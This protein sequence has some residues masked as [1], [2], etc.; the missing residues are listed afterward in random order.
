[1]VN[2]N[3][4][5]DLDSFIEPKKEPSITKKCCGN[6]YSFIEPYCHGFNADQPKKTTEDQGIECPA[7]SKGRLFVIMEKDNNKS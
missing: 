3:N 2:L 5:T 6:C 7:Y 1:V 4:Q